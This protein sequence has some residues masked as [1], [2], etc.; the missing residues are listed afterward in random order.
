M[1]RG[2]LSSADG[3]VIIPSAQIVKLAATL[4]NY[5]SST[6][7]INP[8]DTVTI[9][10]SNS[11]DMAVV[12]LASTFCRAVAAPISKS[13]RE[14]GCSA[15]L[16]EA[17]TKLLILLSKDNEAFAVSAAEKL[18]IPTLVVQ[19]DTELHLNI[20]HQEGPEDVSL[21]AMP[22]FHIHGI[23][24]G[25]LA[26]LAAGSH[27]VLPVEGQ[28]H[29]ETFWRDACQHKITWF[30]AVPTIHQLL[31]ARSHTDILQYPR[32]PLR[33]IRS[34]SSAL[35]PAL[36]SR[37]ESTYNVPVLEA[38]AMTEAS[39]QM[40]SNPLPANGKRKPGSVGMAQGSIAV[41]IL[42][43]QNKPMSRPNAAGE[44]AIRGPS[45]MSGY[46]NCKEEAS[47]EAF[48]GGWFHTGDQGFLDE[49]GYLILTG[50]IK[51]LI[52]VAG[53]KVSPLE[54]DHALLSH[55]DV[56]EAVA[57]ASPDELLG[58]VVEAVVV[59]HRRNCEPGHDQA[60]GI[61]SF[62][63]SRL[64]KEKVPRLI[65]IEDAIPKSATGK[66]QRRN[67]AQQ[68]AN[69]DPAAK[70]A[71]ATGGSAAGS[72]HSRE[73]LQ[74]MVHQAW[75][76]VLGAPP[77]N[78]T[79]S[80]FSQGAS[81]MNA[82]AFA[83]K[84]G[85]TTGR[86]LT[87]EFAFVHPSTSSMVEAL[88]QG[89][90]SLPPILPGSITSDQKSRAQQQ[91]SRLPKLIL[92][93]ADYSAWEHTQLATEA[94]QSN[95]AFW[96]QELEGYRTPQ[97]LQAAEDKQLVPSSLVNFHV[98]AATVDALTRKAAGCGATLFMMLAAAFAEAFSQSL[99]LRDL[100]FLRT[101]SLRRMPGLQDCVGCLVDTVPFRVTSL[102]SSPNQQSILQQVQK[103]T[104][105][106]LKH[107]YPG[108]LV[109]KDLLEAS[110]GL[111]QIDRV[112]INFQDTRSTSIAFGD[113]D[114]RSIVDVVPP[115]RPGAALVAIFQQTNNGLD[116]ALFYDP[117]L[118]LD[119]DITRIQDLFETQLS[120]WAS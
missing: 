16:S 104:Q 62:L 46:V 9:V 94:L 15:A 42:D 59:L 40:C 56:A 7:G 30:T 109:V 73:G 58:E 1:Q 51:E 78:D 114:T 28:F 82:I 11:P 112:A 91:P 4:A 19:V 105:Q 89:D 87:G 70:E 31:L 113:L 99:S 84:L 80:F 96:A 83:S 29:A 117:S 69:G 21:L 116:T 74:E 100:V 34:C 103:S 49:E 35:A 92:Q 64:T 22:L 57:F 3:Q 17:G 65:H 38:Y 66:V 54:V 48:Q 50:R 37:L 8:A 33:F 13:V 45:I 18:G 95:R 32:P 36:L 111:A 52:N 76:S 106:S 101:S 53:E 2:G 10:S 20:C 77:R 25:L 98:N 72:S 75:Q 60:A 23:V 81:S 107:W 68:Y 67:I 115:G 120:S 47:E 86:S 93:E 110:N 108:R 26:P 12:F 39:H 119:A 90:A 5:L 97:Q 102:Q 71:S 55:K 43:E 14:E 44:V 6:C 85:R 41:I 61:C 27:V 88:I 118:F 79:D 63:A 24:A